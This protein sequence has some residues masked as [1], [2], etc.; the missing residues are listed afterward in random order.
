M[1]AEKILGNR[2]I[3][4]LAS[5]VDTTLELKLES[6]DVLFVRE[7][8]EVFPKDLLGLPLDQEIEFVIK[9]Y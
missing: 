8:L 1:K 2:C 5:V 3:G 7:F 6:K 4:Y 9:L